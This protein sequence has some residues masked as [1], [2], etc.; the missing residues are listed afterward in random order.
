[1]LATIVA[2][3]LVDRVGRRFL[4]LEGGAQCSIAL[5]VLALLIGIAFTGDTTTA[6]SMC[7]A[8]WCFVMLSGGVYAYG[9]SWLCVVSLTQACLLTTH[10]GGM[11]I[12]ILVTMCVFIT[13]V[14]LY[15]WLL[16][17]YVTIIGVRDHYWC[18]GRVC[19]DGHAR[20]TYVYIKLTTTT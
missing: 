7:D 2:I 13:G 6:S 12:G 8:V 15:Y 1:M 5:G 14:C 3:V 10:T 11:A 20:V 4:F 9:A 19:A 17:L 18:M 16:L